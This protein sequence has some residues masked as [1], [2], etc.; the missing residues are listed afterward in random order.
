MPSSKPDDGIPT[1]SGLGV[2]RVGY[3]L[4]GKYE[5]LRLIGRGGMGAVFEAE[6]KITQKRVAIKWL[7]PELPA[8]G[9]AAVRLVREAQAASR[10]RHS[11]V[12]DVYDVEREAP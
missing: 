1:A 8:E 6:N 5:I 12:V 2:P 4:G 7:H 11:N 9:G 3:V 10:I